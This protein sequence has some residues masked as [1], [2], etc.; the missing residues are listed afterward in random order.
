VR[1]RNDC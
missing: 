1:L